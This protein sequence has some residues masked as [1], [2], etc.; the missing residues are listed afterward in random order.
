[1]SLIK[2]R[3]ALPVALVATLAMCS[4]TTAQQCTDYTSN[5]SSCSAAGNGWPAGNCGSGC[6]A[7][8]GA[9]CGTGCGAGCGTGCGG[10]G[11]Y[12]DGFE[13]FKE[14]F[15]KVTARN[16]AWPLPFNCWDRESY[17]SIW[18]QQYA[19]GLQVAHMLT[20][21]YFD[22]NSNR[23]NRAG[24]TRVAWIMQ[25]SPVNDKQIFVYEDQTGPAMDQKMASVRDVV[26]RWYSHMG[27]VQ[28]AK[29][30]LTP[31]RIPA[32]YQ[33]TILEQATGSQPPPV[34]PIGSGQ[35]ISS[36]VN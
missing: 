28:I 21:E 31:N 24:E 19:H 7:A 4:L 36:S 5:C 3:L 16:D 18:N 10:C 34:I 2:T 13:K 17:Y 22:Q 33:Q 25:N 11:S 14:D 8:C 26:D 12:A 32:S 20:A 6:G 35:N 30:Q 1:M 15:A 29:S 23:L 27:Q 9:G